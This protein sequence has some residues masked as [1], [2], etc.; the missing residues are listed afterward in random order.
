VQCHKT[1]GDLG[2]GTLSMRFSDGNQ[3]RFSCYLLLLKS[4]RN[5]GPIYSQ[6]GLIPRRSAAVKLWQRLK[7]MVVNP[8][9]TK[10]FLYKKKYP[11]AL[12][13]GFF[14]FFEN[15]SVSAIL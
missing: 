9:R 12:P 14:I 15:V 1:P 5:H 2:K 13:R 4:L 3:P 6:W 11:A 8:T 7:F 10:N